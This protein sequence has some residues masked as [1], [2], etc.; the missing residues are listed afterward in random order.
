[1]AKKIV[2]PVEVQASVAGDQSVKSFK[3]QLREAKEEALRLAATFGETDQRTLAAAIPPTKR[4][5]IAS[6]ICV[7]TRPDITSAVVQ[8]MKKSFLQI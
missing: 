8:S 4:P 1:M 2:Q 5:I 7:F 3:A 6:W